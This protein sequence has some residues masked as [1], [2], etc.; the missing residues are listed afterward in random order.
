[1]VIWN[2]LVIEALARFS[3]VF[4]TAGRTSRGIGSTKL[5][6]NSYKKRVKQLDEKD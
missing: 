1:M 3:P 4:I 6:P 2:L 5:R